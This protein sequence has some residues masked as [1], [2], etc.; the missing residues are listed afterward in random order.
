M[1]DQA[2]AATSGMLLQRENVPMRVKERVLR[3]LEGPQ[4]LLLRQVSH[5][6]NQVIDLHRGRQEERK[7]NG[8]VADGQD[9][10]SEGSDDASAPVVYAQV[11][12]DIK[13]V[14]LNGKIN[15][16][17]SSSAPVTNQ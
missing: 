10:S 3:Y 9:L 1:V 15:K 5:S 17:V 13:D 14:L 8:Q 7:A 16:K 4:K 2:A 6:M 11:M 12:A